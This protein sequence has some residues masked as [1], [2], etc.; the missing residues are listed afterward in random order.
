MNL[1]ED[2]DKVTKD[3]ENENKEQETKNAP[4]PKTFEDATN[5]ALAEFKPKY[6]HNKTMYQNGKE[7]V[8]TIGLNKALQDDDF[9]EEVAEGSK[10]EIRNDMDAD[11]K[12][13][14][15][16]L[17]ET[18]Y[19]KHKPVLRFARLD[20][21][22]SLP[23]MKWMFAITVVPFIISL[24]AGAIG[25]LIIKAFHTINDIFNAIVGVPEYHTNKET[26]DLLLDENGKPIPKKVRVNLLTKILFWFGFVILCA[27]I[28]LAVVKSLTGFDVV[29]AI[30]NL[31]SG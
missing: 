24:I 31:V 1:K 16:K 8:R 26:G 17:Q 14:E 23:L 19:R 30:R 18:F 29:Q 21:H 10:D 25:S 11:K 28:V 6:D 22:C 2:L 12:E 4:V 13:S 7:I 3:I 5:Q 9:I 15:I 27:V 20:E